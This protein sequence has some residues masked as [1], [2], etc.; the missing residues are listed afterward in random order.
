M[1]DHAAKPFLPDCKV[2]V[3]VE[4]ALD[5]QWLSAALAGASGGARVADVRQVEFIKTMA[6][7]IRFTVAFE[8]SAARHAF[9]IKGLLDIDEGNKSL[10]QTCVTEAD[11][12]IKAAPK[13]AVRVPDC[14]SAI[15]DR[16]AQQAA[17]IM[18]DLIVEGA[19]FCSALDTFTADDASSSLEQIAHLHSSADVLVDEPWIGP[20][21]VQISRM[22]A[23]TGDMIQ[24]LMDDPRGENLTP[25][26]RSG[27]NILTAMRALADRTEKRPQFPVHG[28]AHAGNIYRTPEGLGLIDWQV[29]QSGG[30]ALDLAYHINAVLPAEVAEQEERR[31]LEEYL[32][33][34]RAS[35]I[36]MPDDEEAWM[37]YREAVAYGLFMWS[38]T[39][40][41][42]P[43]IIHRFTDRLGKAA[44]RHD[45][46]RLLGAI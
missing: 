19:T 7:K 31:L 21:S 1:S 20:R 33:R 3:S 32:Q 22:P 16:D 42:E 10:G 27:T 2:P 30:W 11:F 8:G 15:V 41:V 28:D 26:I 14:V 6:T 38:I 37:Q 24:Q 34:M 29:L 45:T 5:P 13:F 36:D 4:E 39:R 40:R 17:I 25:E 46:F 43:P 9:C 44:M 35:G 18:R 12:Y 23:F